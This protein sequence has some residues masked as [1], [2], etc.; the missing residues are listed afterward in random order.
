MVELP[1][2]PNWWV[3]EYVRSPDP[4]CVDIVWRKA[5]FLVDGKAVSPGFNSR[6]G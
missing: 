5:A 2:P 6:G 4:T 3:G 1:A